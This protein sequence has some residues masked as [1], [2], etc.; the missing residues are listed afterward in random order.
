MSST[1]RPLCMTTMRSASVSASSTSWVTN[2]TVRRGAARRPPTGRAARRE[3]A[4]RHIVERAERLVEQQHLAAIGEDGGDGDALQHAAGKLARPG[5]LDM[6]EADPREIVARDLAAARLGATP[7]HLR[8]Y[9]TLSIDPHPGKHAVA[10]EH[11]AAFG[12]RP[13]DLLAFHARWRRRRARRGRR[14]ICN[15]V[16]LPQPD[17]PTR[18]TN[19]PSGTM[20]ETSSTAVTRL[21]SAR[22]IRGD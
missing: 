13:V 21:P 19:S 5:A 10:L 3:L 18:Q 7:R 12:A 1:T 15:S 20:N 11:H 16:L 9:S 4:A 22:V 14:A 6:R 8:P 17:G 2:S